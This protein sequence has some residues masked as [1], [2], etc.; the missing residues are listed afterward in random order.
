MYTAA[1]A[2]D[3]VQAHVADALAALIELHEDLGR[4]LPPALHPLI[5]T[6]G[7]PIWTEDINR[8]GGDV[9]YRK[10]PGSY[11]S[12]AVRKSVAGAGARI[13]SSTRP[14]VALLLFPTGAIR[15]S[16]S[17]RYATSSGS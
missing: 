13:A 2:L 1:D 5:T 3:E 17:V 14:P 8:G 16:K 11:A 7:V 9:K 15:I 12:S 10:S 6:P 4:P